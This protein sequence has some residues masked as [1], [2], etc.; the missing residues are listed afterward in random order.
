MKAGSLR[1][2]ITIETPSETSDGLGGMTTTW[3]TLKSIWA[4]VMPLRGQEYIGA[5]Q[6][7]SEISHRVRI[8]YM[9][10]VTPKQRIK[11]GDRY[12]DIESVLNP[13]ERNIMLEL[14]CIEQTPVK[15]G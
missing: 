11:W 6:T 14:M 12:F 7:T 15:D 2:K 10:G 3:N 1:H 13:S 5:M 4:A 9:S 8:R